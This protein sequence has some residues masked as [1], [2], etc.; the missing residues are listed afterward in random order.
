MSLAHFLEIDKAPVKLVNLINKTLNGANNQQVI[1][2][3][4]S[5]NYWLRWNAVEIRKTAGYKVDLVAIYILDL[6]YSDKWQTR[7]NA[8]LE[9]G[10]L[11]DK[12]AIPALKKAKNKRMKDP[13]V[14]RTARRVL[15]R[16]FQQ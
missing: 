14:S 2:W 1:V 15:R 12:R 4:Q 13:I 11:A 8:I 16:V 3:L 5:T 9:L 10:K 6:T 7:R